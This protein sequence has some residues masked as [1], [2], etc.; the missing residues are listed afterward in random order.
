MPG[1][2]GGSV[3]ILAGPIIA[4]NCRITASDCVDVLGYQVRPMEYMLFPKNIAVFQHDYSPTH[5]QS[6]KCSVF[7]E[8]HE[9]VLQHLRW[10]AQSPDLNII[11]PLWSMNERKPT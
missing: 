6:Q 4:L 1:S 10:P 8:Q 2:T 11:T 7:D 5:T 3:V 9:D